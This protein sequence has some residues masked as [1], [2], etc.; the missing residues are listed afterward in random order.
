M[1][2]QVSP[3]EGSAVTVRESSSPT[4]NVEVLG[5]SMTTEPEGSVDPSPHAAR[6]RKTKETSPAGSRFTRHLT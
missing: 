1:D 4:I 2:V 5:G 6:E 3:V